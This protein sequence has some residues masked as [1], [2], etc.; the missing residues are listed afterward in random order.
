MLKKIYCSF[1]YDKIGVL[2]GWIN[3]KICMHSTNHLPG[4]EPVTS[5]L[6]VISAG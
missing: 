5:G 6:P 1:S 3:W 4:I 2:V